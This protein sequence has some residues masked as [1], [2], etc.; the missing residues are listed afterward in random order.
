MTTRFFVMLL[1]TAAIIAVIEL[2]LKC[3]SNNNTGEIEG[4][5]KPHEAHA[6]IEA[7][8]NSD[9]T[10]AIPEEDGEFKIRGLN[11]AVY[12]VLYKAAAP[13]RDT[14]INNIQ[15]HTWR[16]TNLPLITLHH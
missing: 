1:I 11:P 6:T 10:Y 4:I 16:N 3:Y 8:K 7:Y 5:V 15:I 13:Y 12:S 14:V 2:K 9:T